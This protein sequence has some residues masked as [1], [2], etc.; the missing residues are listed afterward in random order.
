VALIPSFQPAAIGIADASVANVMQ[1]TI[2]NIAKDLS[3]TTK[4][5]TAN[6]RAD[7]QR[8]LILE[9]SAKGR[10]GAA[11]KAEADAW[12]DRAHKTTGEAFLGMTN[13]DIQTRVWQP[14]DGAA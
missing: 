5:Q 1:T 10:L 8:A 13:Q 14:V 6:L 12:F 7:Q 11:T 9:L 2:W 3:L 4:I